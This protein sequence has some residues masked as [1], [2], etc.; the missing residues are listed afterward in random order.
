[1]SEDVEVRVSR[2]GATE[3]WTLDRPAQRNALSKGVVRELGRLARAAAADDSVRA[4]VLTGAGDKA[5]CSG[6]DLKERRTMAEADV[7]DFLALYRTEFRFVDELPKPV[8]AAINGVAFGG[9]LELALCCDLR[10]I[11][12]TAEVGLTE[13]SLGI[14]PGAGGTQRLVRI[15]GAAK[16]KELLLFSRRLS[17]SD[18]LALGLVHRV[19]EPGRSALEAAL[20]WASILERGAPIAMAAALEAI[21]AAADLPLDAGLVVEQRC[22]E[23]TL[24]SSDRVE[25]LAA[26]AEKR[27]P[28]F[29]GR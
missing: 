14:I 1:M 9:G 13:V 21:D 26:F 23:R 22:Y 7:R 4:I 19:A 15:V 29:R 5:F 18:A 2:H 10:V 17:A 20:E 6:A 11:A 24:V 12:D 8:I 25:A 3:V 16:A 27:P 28:V